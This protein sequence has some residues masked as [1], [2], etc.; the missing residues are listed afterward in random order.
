M[1]A[2]RHFSSPS[3]S[4]LYVMKIAHARFQIRQNTLSDGD[5]KICLSYRTVLDS[6]SGPWRHV[7]SRRLGKQSEPLDFNALSVEKDHCRTEFKT[8]WRPT[9]V[10]RTSSMYIWSVAVLLS[11]VAMSCTRKHGALRPQKP[12]RLTKDGEVGRSGIL[13]LTPTCYNVTTRMILH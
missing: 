10:R 13:Y 5:V 3:D 9:D 8:L 7:G 4:V 2:D 1:G 12:V 6:G 11:C